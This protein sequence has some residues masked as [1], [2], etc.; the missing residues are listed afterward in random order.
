MSTYVKFK[1]IFHQTLKQL[2]GLI[3]TDIMEIQDDEMSLIDSCC[4]LILDASK[5]FYDNLE[6]VQENS[7]ISFDGLTKRLN[8]FIDD[9]IDRKIVIPAAPHLVHVIFT[10]LTN[11]LQ[12]DIFDAFHVFLLTRLLRSIINKELLERNRIKESEKYKLN[13]RNTIKEGM[14]EILLKELGSVFD[15][16]EMNRGCEPNF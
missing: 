13:K 6:Y 8:V 9:Q 7:T 2:D 16:E 4:A 12:Q 14:K 11:L 10:E 3:K 15:L 5:D 1:K